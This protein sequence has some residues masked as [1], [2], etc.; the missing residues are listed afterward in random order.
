M[1]KNPSVIELGPIVALDLETTGLRAWEEKIDLIALKTANTG[2]VLEAEKYDH[3][4]LVQLFKDLAKCDLVIAHNAKFDAGFIYYHY[5][6]L[7]KNL[8]CTQMGAEICENGKQRQLRKQYD[9]KPFTLVATLSRWLGIRHKDAEKKTIWQKSF[10]DKA[11]SPLYRLIPQVRAK[12][13]AYAYED[14]EYLEKLYQAELYRIESLGLGI[15]NKLEHKL[16]PIIVKME[17]EGCLIDRI[18]WADLVKTY[19][20]PEEKLIQEQLDAEVRKLLKGR[21]FKYTVDRKKEAVTQFDLFGSSSTEEITGS[22]ELSYTS[23]DQ[24]I[25]LIEF[26]GEQVPT[27]GDGKQSLEEEQLL[28]YLTEHGDSPLDHFFEILLKHRKISKMISTYGDKFLAKLDKNNHIHTE[29]TQT[30]TETGRASS[31][32]P[33]LQ[34]IPAAPKNDPTKDIRRFFIARPGYK[35]ITCDMNGAEVAIAADYSQEPLLLAALRDGEDMHSKLASVSY[36]IIFN[37]PITISK[38]ETPF[39]ID[40]KTYIPVELRDEHKSV[41]FAKFYKGGAAR[42]Y[43]VLNEYINAHWG[44]KDR[45]RISQEISEALDKEMPVLSA[46]LSGLIV[47]AQTKGFLRD[48]SFNRIRYFDVEKVYGEAANYPVQGTNG[49]AIKMAIV[50]FDSIIEKKNYDA[51]I[52]MQVHDE[53]LVEAREDIVDDVAK[54]LKETMADSLSYFLKTIKG[55]ASVSIAAHWK[56]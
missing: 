51:R 37:R 26:L 47:E 24:I 30:K 27:T 45:K 36:S 35:F 18:G 39:E 11:K 6:V 23:T 33:N 9:G 49:E 8:F 20:E 44:P 43:G 3:N 32:S 13:I 7:L 25:E 53:L 56:K 17:I 22:N 54:D 34:N 14:V 5:G 2:Y 41:V 42:I 48:S 38:S 46:Y 29:Y 16:L 55:G 31:K 10:I 19:W 1:I 15:I 4:Y 21:Q 40:G 50:N 52:V 28:V 12:Q